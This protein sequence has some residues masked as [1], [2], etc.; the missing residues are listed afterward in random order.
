MKKERELDFI[1]ILDIVNYIEKSKIDVGEVI[2]LKKSR[3]TN[4]YIAVIYYKYLDIYIVNN[5]YFT[6]QLKAID[7]FNKL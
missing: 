3:K 2:R 1:K 5:L 4:E 6:N 7:Y